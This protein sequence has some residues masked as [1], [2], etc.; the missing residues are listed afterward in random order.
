MGLSQSLYTGWTGMATHQR[1]LDNTG[2]NLANINTVGFKKSDFYFSNLFN[3]ALNGGN[4]PANDI[5]GSVNPKTVGV[6]VTTGAITN[7]FKQ[8]PIE[9]TGNPLDVAINGGGFFLAGTPSG[10][11][12]TR[13]G[14]FYIDQTISPQRRML[15]VGDGLPVQ[16]WMANEGVVTPTTTVGNIYL[17]AIGDLLP[18]KTTTK[19][20][21][22]GVLPTNTSSSDFNGR[23]TSEVD[24]KGN[25]SAGNN[26]LTTHIY[27][28][29]TQT[30]GGS[31]TK[32]DVVE[33]IKVQIAFSG[34]TQSPDGTLNNWTWTMETVDWPNA[35]DPPV[36]IYPPPSDPSFSQGTVSFYA[37]SNLTT[38]KGEGEAATH[39]VKPGSTKVTTQTTDAQGNIVTTSFNVPGD[40]TVDTSRLT[41]LPDAPGGNALETWSVNGNPKGTMA[42]TI[43]VYDEY[44]DFVTATDASGNA[45]VSPARRVEAREDTLI[46]KQTE[47]DDAGRTWSW[48]SSV[49]GDSGTLRFNTIGDLVSTTGN[50]GDIQYNFSDMRNINYAGSVQIAAQDGYRDGNL[51]YISID[52]YGKLF[53]H[54][55]ND[56]TEVLAQLAMGTVPNPS[57]MAGVSGTLFYPDVASGDL[58][59]GTAGDAGGSSSGLA[60]IGAGS[61]VTSS[62]ESSNVDLSQEFSTLITTE[63]GYQ[64]NGKIV[65]TSDEMLQTALGLKR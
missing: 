41:T 30:D 27:A 17:P 15:C 53:G 43:T 6:G 59:I 9:S 32:K 56:V 35:G 19:V 48:S 8:A 21:L 37:E 42:R 7:N 10:I 45:A 57:G 36:Q 11:A 50:T 24:L 64:L 22:T 33:E 44:T 62:L 18:G 54:Y 5:R 61:L 25:L 13:N 3:Q 55:S 2:N 39:T 1:C 26:T 28:P 34:P 38:G 40:F 51:E 20:D 63:R 31:A 52:Q 65:T 12:L 29:V 49:N 58:M 14:S 4:F 46:F 23:V 60:P 16:G 47:S